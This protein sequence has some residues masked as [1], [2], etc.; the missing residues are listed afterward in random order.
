MTI[1]VTR[2][3]F[4]SLTEKHYISEA[5]ESNVYALWENYGA[6]KSG[7]EKSKDKKPY[8]VV[9]PPPNVTGR[10]HMGHALNNTLQDMF[11]RFKR[12][13]GYDACWIP[14]TDHAGISTQSVVKKQLQAEGIDIRE[15]GRKKTI[16]RIWLWKERYG[17]KIIDQL[18]RMG[19]SCDWDRTAFTMSNELS[20]AVRHAFVSL[21]EAGLVYRG[22]YIVN[23]CPVDQTALSND[24]T[25]T[26]EGGEA[27]HLW[28][29]NYPLIG[30]PIGS[31]ITIATTRPETMFGDVA[32]AVNPKDERYKNLIGHFVRLPIANR[33]IPIIADEY[34]DAEFGT[35]CLKITPAHDPNDY[36][37]G[38]RHNLPQIDIMQPNACLNNEVPEEFRGLDR[39]E[40]RKKVVL[41]MSELGLL[42]KVEE[43]MTPLTRAE[44][45][46]AVIE[47]RLCDQWFVKMKPLAEEALKCGEL[48]GLKFFPPRWELVY[49]SWLENT[50]DWCISRQI[51][52]G[53]RIPAW[54]NKHD[55]RVVVSRE[56][57]PSEVEGNPNDWYQD[58]DV[59]D[60][61][62][63][64][65]LWPYSTFGWPKETSDLKRFYP[66]SVLVTAKDIIY[67]W[68]ARMVMT[69][70]FHLKQLPFEQVLIN[71]A[72]CDEEGEIMSKS[73]GNGI[74]PLHVIDGATREELEE[75]VQE[76]RPLDMEEKLARIRQSYPNG[77]EG[78]GADALRF[79]LATLNSE[80]Q[81]V[82]VG[83]KRFSEVGRPFTDKLWNACRFVLSNLETVAQVEAGP[84]KFE[85][86]WIVGSLDRC[87]SIMRG[88][89]ET[90]RRDVAFEQAYHFFWDDFCDWYL[91]IAKPRLRS[92]DV[93]D[94]TRVQHTLAEVLASMIRALHPAVPF[95][96]EEL[97]GHL[98]ERCRL[99]GLLTPDL[100]KE[101]LCALAPY[102]VDENRFNSQECCGFDQLREVVRAIRTARLEAQI[103]PKAG[104]VAS[105]R[106]TDDTKR[107]F[108]ESNQSLL[109]SAAG[110][111]SW[112]EYESSQTNRTV[113][114]LEG[115]EVHLDLAAHRDVSAEKARNVKLLEQIGARV[116]H[117]EQRLSNEDFVKKAPAPIIEKERK[118]LYELLEQKEKVAGVLAV[119]G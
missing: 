89:I 4:L 17:N 91:E 100:L 21:F 23:W 29:F 9:I 88:A 31:F 14:G 69:G 12:M 49:K 112:G 54:Y 57:L 56:G 6:F 32:V 44:R 60:T 118:A 41:V 34:V 27:G 70:V 81:Q 53:H 28:H 67:L 74:D 51:W 11:V 42:A 20:I 37:I 64:S 30:G 50:K 66:T 87:I 101:D 10:L 68:V 113:L 2:P 98:I 35:G 108:F 110:L 43:R 78:I 119:L 102:P 79:T 58:E 73:K 1:K 26:K 63:S 99:F 47:Y 107:K 46:K 61:W 52:W 5:V 77:F 62:F 80:A 33:E 76:A 59:L 117:L 114:I 38:L 55:G 24:E 48:Q 109:L 94:R 19:C 93:A 83:M 106:Y 71:P 116:L 96:T 97:W 72:I 40:A 92:D 22:K 45:S 104:I 95:I 90:F 18:R 85:D 36:Q 84:A 16:E 25:Y 8:S 103:S 105:V 75:V 82:G 15:Y 111:E 39:H 115:L 3:T 7:Q 13:D 65:A 86:K